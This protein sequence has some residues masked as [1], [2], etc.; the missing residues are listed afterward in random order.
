MNDQNADE[1]LR[2][3]LQAADPA[4]DGSEPGAEEI[5]RLRR[6]T[7]N[8]VPERHRT[9]HWLPIAAAAA[10]VAAVLVLIPTGPGEEPLPSDA[11]GVLTAG[12]ATQPQRQQIQFA[13]ESGTRIIW[14][15]DPELNL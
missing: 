8:Q 13:T 6:L 3:L 12:R 5:A 9:W 7:L 15:L 1:R 11:S 10:L 4:A 2:A 14:V